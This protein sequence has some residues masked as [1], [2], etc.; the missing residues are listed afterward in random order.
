[1]RGKEDKIKF[2]E[3]KK[4]VQQRMK[5]EFHVRIDQPRAGG[6]G[7]SDTGAV[8]RKL[9]KEPEKLAEVLHLDKDVVKRISVVMN[10]VCCGEK[11]DPKRFGAYCEETYKKYLTVYF[12]YPPSPS[13][14][15]V[16]EH[17]KDVIITLPVSLGKMGEDGAESQNKYL[18]KDREDHARHTS[19]KDNLTD[20]FHRRLEFSDPVITQKYLKA[21][22]RKAKR[23][24]DLSEEVQQLLLRQ[25]EEDVEEECDDVYTAGNIERRFFE[26]LMDDEENIL[27]GEDFEGDDFD[28]EDY[29]Q[30]ESEDSNSSEEIESS[31]NE[32]IFQELEDLKKC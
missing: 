24:E 14:H 12:W 5:D 31:E 6:A 20:M 2:D 27:W 21:N 25:D 1:V 19:R 10:A 8:A 22:P 9:L 15:K 23:I 26:L 16:L 30:S 13:L 18:R 4:D 3:Q 28:D 17:A 7:T 11:L 32:D 29:E